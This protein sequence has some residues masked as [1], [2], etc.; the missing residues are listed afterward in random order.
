M[1]RT[2]DVTS[3]LMTQVEHTVEAVLKTP[4]AKRL[5]GSDLVK[6]A[7]AGA[8]RAAVTLT[9]VAEKVSAARADGRPARAVVKSALSKTAAKK[10]RPAPAA[11]KKAVPKKGQVRVQS[12]A[13]RRTMPEQISST[14]GHGLSGETAKRAV[15][16]RSAG[17]FKAKKGQR[18]R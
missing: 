15:K 11:A 6:R 17:G 7:Q 14:G 16:N 5:L 9:E 12:A 8:V 13:A 4:T 18:T 1:S 3:K 10:A 2:S